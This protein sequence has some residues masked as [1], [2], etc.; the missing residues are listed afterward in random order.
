MSACFLARCCTYRGG[1]EFAKAGSAIEGT[2]VEA[3]VAI[4][5]CYPSRWAINWQR[6]N[7]A[8]DPIDKLM[9]Y[10]T[11]LRKLGYRVDIVPPE[12]D[13][14]RYKL[15]IAPGLEVLTPAEADNLIRNVSDGGHL[16]RE[17]GRR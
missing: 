16:V 15:V 11:P 9:G 17:S 12:R 14:L 3:Q 4:L 5:H 8:Y 1:G 10:Y 13:L 6:M 7:P 2:R